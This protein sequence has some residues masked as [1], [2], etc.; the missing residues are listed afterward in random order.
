MP[1]TTEVPSQILSLVAKTPKGLTIDELEA[2]LSNKVTPR[3]MREWARELF[4]SGKLDRKFE[5][6]QNRVGRYRYF[7]KETTP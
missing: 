3:I 4:T 2:K 7:T 1:R 5:Y 6:D